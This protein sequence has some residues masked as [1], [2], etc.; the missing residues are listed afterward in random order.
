MGLCI[1]YWYQFRSG[2]PKLYFTPKFAYSTINLP[3]D[4]RFGQ[5]HRTIH[6]HQ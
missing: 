2:V 5:E 6:I 4:W 3:S 1:S